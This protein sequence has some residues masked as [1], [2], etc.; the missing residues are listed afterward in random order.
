MSANLQIQQETSGFHLHLFQEQTQ[1][2]L[3]SC[4]RRGLSPGTIQYYS[5]HLLGLERFLASR[6]EPLHPS[7]FPELLQT[8]IH[9]MSIDGYAHRTKVGRF[10]TCRQFYQFL[11]SD[12]EWSP[13]SVPLPDNK[14][15]FPEKSDCFTQAE[16]IRILAQ[17]NRRRFTG[18][19]DYT[20]L[21]ILMDTGIRLNELCNLKLS[22]IDWQDQVIRITGGKGNKTRYVPIQETCLRQIGSYLEFRSNR[23][24]DLLW[25][26]QDG[27]PFQRASILQM[28]IKHCRGAGVRGSAHTFR[29]TMAKTFLMNGGSVFALQSILGHTTLEMTRQYVQLL[30]MDLH[31]KHETCSPVESLLLFA[32]EM[33]N[34][35]ELHP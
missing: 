31:A 1:R 20:M 13:L 27:Q 17:P 21:L 14:N 29:H 28:V 30:P 22:D 6:K 8:V 3:S 32:N 24:H 4:S 10:H 35:K 26:T 18:Y 15:S 2:F 19:R 34:R 9:D 33:K 5:F 12:E 7:T 11:F 23:C 25:I 16:V